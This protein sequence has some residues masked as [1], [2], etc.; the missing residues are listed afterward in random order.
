MVASCTKSKYAGDTII[1]YGVF[2]FFEDV[3]GEKLCPRGQGDSAFSENNQIRQNKEDRIS[4]TARRR[5]FSQD[6]RY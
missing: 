1:F 5:S 4:K 3:L 2:S 6:K